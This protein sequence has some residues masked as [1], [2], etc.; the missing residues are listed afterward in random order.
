MQTDVLNL[1]TMH[2]GNLCLELTECV[3]WEEYPE[4][5]DEFMGLIG[6]R[7]VNKNDAPDMGIWIIEIGAHKIRIVYEDYPQM[8][9]LEPN[10]IDSNE[11]IEKLFKRL[12]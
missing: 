2:S 12:K 4:Y 6:G 8:I 3:S 7:I 1:T 10:D 5:V 9:S 11:L